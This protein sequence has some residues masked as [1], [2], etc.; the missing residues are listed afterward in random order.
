MRR[1]L[2]EV[3]AENRYCHRLRGPDVRAL[4]MRVNAGKVPVWSSIAKAYTV[5]E[6]T[7]ANV[8]ALAEHRGYDVVVTGPRAV[9]STTPFAGVHDCDDSGEALW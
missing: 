1:R 3:E 6:Q 9:A 8:I 7:A 4:A 2:L 5:S